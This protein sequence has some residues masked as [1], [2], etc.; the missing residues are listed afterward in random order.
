ME[1]IIL[2]FSAPDAKTAIDSFL[3]LVAKQEGSIEESRYMLLGAE[4]TGMMR[5]SGNWHT[6]AKIEKELF[7]LKESQPEL[8]LKFKRSILP[9]FPE[10][11][12]PYVLQIVGVNTST[13]LNEVAH[14]F[15]EQ[16]I[17]IIDMQTDVSKSNYSDTKLLNLVMRL[18]IP[19]NSINISDLRERFMLLCEDNN[20]DAILEPEKTI[21]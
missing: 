19:T 10:N 6:I 2:L 15:I 11:H 3:Y 13:L 12:L 1:D 21:K 18:H 16:D 20:V 9:K 17:Q 8:W 5:I 14:F 4:W 7:A